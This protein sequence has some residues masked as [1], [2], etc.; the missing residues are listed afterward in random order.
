MKAAVGQIWASN[1]QRDI[2]HNY[3]QER[4]VTSVENGRAFL[5]TRD[6]SPYCGSFGVK[7]AADG[8][9]SRHRYVSPGLDPQRQQEAAQRA[10]N[11]EAEAKDLIQQAEALFA[12]ATSIRQSWNLPA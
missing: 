1:D 2:A 8:S 3:R 12:Q 4:I 6:G 11:I 9:V 7:L 5:K 10:D